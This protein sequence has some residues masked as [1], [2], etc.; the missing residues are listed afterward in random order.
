MVDLSQYT[1]KDVIDI[2]SSDAETELKN[3]VTNKKNKKYKNQ[4]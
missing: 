3:D 1:D 4:K 2:I